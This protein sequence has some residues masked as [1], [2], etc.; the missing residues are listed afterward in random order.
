MPGNGYERAR[1]GRERRPPGLERYRPVH[2]V[3]AFFLRVV[4][5]GG[6]ATHRAQ[7]IKHAKGPAGLYPSGD[8]PP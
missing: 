2:D 5:P 6:A 7:L 8:H 1:S 3:E 4:V